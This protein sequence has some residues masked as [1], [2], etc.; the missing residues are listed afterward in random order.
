MLDLPSKIGRYII[1]KPLG[2]GAM[3]RVFL[4]HDPIL[5]RKVAI[6]VLAVDRQ[7]QNE[8]RINYISH[9]LKEAKSSARLNH[10][11]IVQVYDAG[12]E[13]G[14]PWIAF[15]YVEGES[16]DA[17]LQQRKSLTIRRTLLFTL[18]I[19]SAL[20]H[21]HS[22]GI[23]HRDVKPA[24][25][26]VEQKSGIA[27]LAD[28]GIAHAKAFMPQEEKAAIGTPGYMSPEQIDGKD[29][30]ERSDL[31]SLGVVIYQMLTGKN[32]FI[33]N[34]LEATFLAT[35]KGEYVPLRDLIEDIPKPLD[36]AVRRCLFPNIKM[37]M[38]SAS[39]LIDIISPLIIEGESKKPSSSSTTKII[40]ESRFKNSLYKPS[41]FIARI[42]FK[43]KLLRWYLVFIEFIQKSFSRLFK[44]KELYKGETIED[45]LTI[46]NSW[47]K[48]PVNLI[49]KT[50][51]KL[52]H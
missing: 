8:Q 18:D 45:V 10:P 7:I 28:F 21:A 15:M 36:A 31:F 19:A 49:R 22:W 24:N 29:I 48:F 47:I 4:A 39:E 2:A 27:M 46:I 12:E 5:D 20:Q 1:I 50:I 52:I 14:E 35:C 6:K 9:F 13:N 41:N 23:I 3:G 42:F 25:I 32:P 38:R 43:L 26:L 16:L 51:K 30:D 17:I 34:T 40:I 33:R 37:R 44:Q 11:S